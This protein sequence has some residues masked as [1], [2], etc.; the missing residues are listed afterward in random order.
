VFEL[1]N[2]QIKKVLGPGD[3]LFGR[4]VRRVE[5]SEAGIGLN[6]AGQ[7]ALNVLFADGGAAVVRADCGE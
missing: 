4:I 5:F 2:G 3:S 1:K 6:D 7:L